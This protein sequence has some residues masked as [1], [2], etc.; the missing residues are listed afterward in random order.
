MDLSNKSLNTAIN[1][2]Q[3]IKKRPVTELADNIVNMGNTLLKKITKMSPKKSEDAASKAIDHDE[4]VSVSVVLYNKLRKIKDEHKRN[5][6][7]MRV[8]EILYQ[9]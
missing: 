8:F 9:D 3:K 2:A 5:D 1:D 6:F 4:N 7:K